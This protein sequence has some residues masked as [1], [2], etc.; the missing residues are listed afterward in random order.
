MSFLTCRFVGS[1][2][3]AFFRNNR[4]KDDS[5]SSFTHKVA[6]ADDASEDMV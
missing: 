2:L 4:L 6:T 5:Y 1:A 3:H